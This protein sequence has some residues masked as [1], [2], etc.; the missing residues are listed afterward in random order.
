MDT[1]TSL[2]DS[3]SVLAST[4][5]VVVVMMVVGLV[6]VAVWVGIVVGSTVVEVVEVVDVVGSGSTPSLVHPQQASNADT[7]L[8]AKS[9]AGPQES[10]QPGPYPV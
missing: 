2:V 1:D 4:A 9:L 6:V 3:L 5:A 8:T 10:S 7:L